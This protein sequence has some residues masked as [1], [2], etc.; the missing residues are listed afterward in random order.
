MSEAA[1]VQI[2]RSIKSDDTC[3]K[4]ISLICEIRPNGE[5]LKNVVKVLAISSVVAVSLLGVEINFVGDL[6]RGCSRS[7]EVKKI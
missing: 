2:I 3:K 7:F 6:E 5:I 4:I 1:S